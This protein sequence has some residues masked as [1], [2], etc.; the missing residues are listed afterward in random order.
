MYGPL[1]TGLS[2][3]ALGSAVIACGEPN[4]NDCSAMSRKNGPSGL[5]SVTTTRVGDGACTS[6]IAP[7]KPPKSS[8]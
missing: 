7:G 3:N 1:P 2:S 8:A 5:A 4:P 6:T